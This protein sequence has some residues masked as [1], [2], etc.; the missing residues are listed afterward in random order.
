MKSR[1]LLVVY[2]LVLL[3]AT[4]AAGIWMTRLLRGEQRRIA[5]DRRAALERLAQRTADDL[6]LIVEDARDSL[7]DSLAALPPDR[8]PDAL[9]TLAQTH[10]LVRNA[11][12]WSRDRRLIHPNAAAGL[13]AEQ[14]GFIRRYD[15]LFSNS[16]DW[17]VAAA[18]PDAAP[19]PRAEVRKLG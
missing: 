11:F 8:L 13:T 1:A 14:A 16:Q 6:A 10:P 17:P 7:L 12:V 18:P 19:A 5:S 9:D 2:W 3:A 15:R 4:L